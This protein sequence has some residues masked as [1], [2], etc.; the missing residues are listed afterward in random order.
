[1]LSSTLSF[2][3]RFI[4]GPIFRFFQP[5]YH[6]LLAFAGALYFGFPSRGMHVIEV[7]GTKGKSSTVEILAAILRA[8]G[9][10]V[11]SASTIRFSIN[12]EEMPNM[13]KMTVPGRFFLHRFLARA[14]KA[15][16]SHVVLEMS[17]EA[18][19][20]YRNRF[21][22]GSGFIFTN[23]A[24][25]HIESHG[26]YAAYTEAKVSIARYIAATTNTSPL[27]NTAKAKIFVLNA[28]DT[29]T[30]VFEKAIREAAPSPACAIILHYHLDNVKASV[31]DTGISLTLSDRT[32]TTP[33]R[34]AFN[35]KNIIAAWTYAGAIGCTVDDLERALGRL[36]VI[37]GRAE[38]IQTDPFEVVVDY[39]HTKESLEALY[40]AFPHRHAIC[41]LGNT[42]GGRDT[43][44]RSHMA[45]AAANYCSHII[46]TNEDPYDEHPLDIVE[47]MRR[48]IAD[49]IVPVHIIMDR[50]EAIAT[51][52][53]EAAKVHAVTADARSGKKVA[54][55]ITGKGTDPYIM[56][57]RGSKMPWSDAAVARE[58]LVKLATK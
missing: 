48:S 31:T 21:I 30:P 51:A 6:F 57:P 45:K 4:P 17:S 55:L 38:M 1:M 29:M 26:S 20:Q 50:R 37:H 14:R 32:L 27:S 39:A 8:H 5:A 9:L 15:G 28:E 35:A 22:F 34:G 23:L 56:G 36:T 52:L 42:G 40:G 24:P 11:A 25:E 2:I 3:A 43:W 58:E 41:V 49:T 46:L 7:T 12:D 19:R 13:Y 18:A 10:K 53:K 33:L 54:V 44:K 47:S 16:C